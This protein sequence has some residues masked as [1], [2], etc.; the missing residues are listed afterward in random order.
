MRYPDACGCTLGD[1]RRLSRVLT[2]QDSHLRAVRVS[3]LQRQQP[4]TRNSR[5]MCRRPCRLH[6][7]Y[8]DVCSRGIA[9]G[10]KKYGQIGACAQLGQLDPCDSASGWSAV[11][12]QPAV[13]GLGA[14]KM[15]R[16][17]AAQN[18]LRRSAN[19][20]M[21]AARSSFAKP[22][23]EPSVISLAALSIR[24]DHTRPRDQGAMFASAPPGQR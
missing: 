8:T 11:E 10:P 18:A 4:T 23:V 6:Q 12:A 21:Q 22:P 5:P 14:V 13:S 2:G 16:A 1:I 15:A 24:P 3:P 17:R 19:S 9:V 7:G 20:K